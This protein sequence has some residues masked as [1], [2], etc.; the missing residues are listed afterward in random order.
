MD[1]DVQAAVV[2]RGQLADAELADVACAG[3]LRAQLLRRATARR[4]GM[5]TRIWSRSE[6]NSGGGDAAHRAGG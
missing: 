1:V 2:G 4:S 3:E 6:G 5:A